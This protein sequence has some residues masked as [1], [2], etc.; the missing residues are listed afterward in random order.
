M[1]DI[2]ESELTEAEMT[3]APDAAPEEDVDEAVEVDGSAIG[4]DVTDGES[5]A[6]DVDGGADSTDATAERD[7]L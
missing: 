5:Q 7:E 6:A 2:T 3:L 1:T 4:T